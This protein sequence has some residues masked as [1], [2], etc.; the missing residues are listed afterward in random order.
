MTW[1]SDA[2]TGGQVNLQMDFYI[3]WLY[4]GQKPRMFS[5]RMPCHGG[6]KKQLGAVI[7]SLLHLTTVGTMRTLQ[8]M[9]NL[10]SIILLTWA[11]AWAPEHGDSHHMSNAKPEKMGK[12]DSMRLA[13]PVWKPEIWGND[14]FGKNSMAAS[15]PA[16]AQPGLLANAP[17]ILM[18]KSSTLRMPSWLCWRG[19]TTFLVSN[20]KWR[21]Q[22]MPLRLLLPRA[23]WQ[24]EVATLTEQ[25]LQAH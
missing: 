5:C 19:P 8:L 17:P 9:P 12:T 1:P 13:L 21:A 18:P 3:C 7:A 11:A 24:G 16:E 6:K 23:P 22:G 10:P 25:T 14:E 4:V 2:L 20:S 15:C